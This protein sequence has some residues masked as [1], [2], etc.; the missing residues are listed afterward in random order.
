MSAIINSEKEH[1]PVLLNEL[2]N[3]IS[4]HYDGTFID[5][6]FGNGGDSKKILEHK[7]NN[8]LAIDRDEDCKKKALFFKKKF[9]KRFNFHNI[10]FANL[11]EIKFQKNKLKGVIFDL[12]YSLDQINN[13]SKGI[14]FKSTGK[15]N[16]Q[17]GLNN[18]S[19]H[20]VINELPYEDLW[21]IFKYFGDEKFCKPIAKRITF[22]R[23]IKNIK[24]EDL[25]KIINSTKKKNFGKINNATK[26]FQSIR[27]FVNEE[28]SQ[29]INGL[30]NAYN[31]L[32]KGGIIAVISFHSIE[33]KIVKFF[34]KEFSQHK[35][36]S[37][38]YPE[39]KKN[40]NK[41]KILNKKPIIPGQDEIKA[42]PPSRSA[43]LRC[44]VKVGTNSDFISF[45]NKFN[46]LI[47][48]ENLSKKL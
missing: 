12:G 7:G 23:K 10:K 42:N 21:K 5:C 3:I 11:N 17:M 37:R 38:Y 22:Q 39:A 43:K 4:P 34:F 24:T 35:N 8:I 15:L 26:V 41:F 31:L 25:I 47:E 29:L 2:V 20:Q 9:N 46:Y 1:F 27:I 6:T 48:I 36:L 14:S 33:D 18:F 28:I 30:I 32:P 19:A 44:A 13:L 45:K 16:M 40:E